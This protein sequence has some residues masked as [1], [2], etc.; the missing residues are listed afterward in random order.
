MDGHSVRRRYGLCGPVE[1]AEL[2]RRGV[3][4]YDGYNRLL[5]IPLLLLLVALL[6]APRALTVPGRSARAGL[7]AAAVG[8][9]LLLAGAVPSTACELAWRG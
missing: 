1:P 9:G 5:A 2:H 4:G 6:A 7:I 8:V 3:L